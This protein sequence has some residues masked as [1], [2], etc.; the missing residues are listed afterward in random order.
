MS[1]KNAREQTG[2]GARARSKIQ[3]TAS[4]RIGARKS[5]D[6]LVKR[7]RLAVRCQRQLVVQIFVVAHSLNLQEHL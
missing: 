7:A 2:L 5:Y 4:E 3:S 1:I 6:A